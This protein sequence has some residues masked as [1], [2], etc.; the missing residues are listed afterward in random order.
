MRI[1]VRDCEIGEVDD[2]VQD[3]GSR[4]LLFRLFLVVF[5]FTWVIQGVSLVRILHGV[6]NAEVFL[7]NWKK[8]LEILLHNYIV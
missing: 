7:S 2:D 8:R 3:G 5:F 6:T 4:K 1:I